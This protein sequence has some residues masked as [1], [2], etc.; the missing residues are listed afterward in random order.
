M[1]IW[2]NYSNNIINI[3]HLFIELNST[4]EVNAD[5]IKDGLVNET[6][7]SKTE[8]FSKT[9]SWRVNQAKIEEI[10]KN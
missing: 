8:E 9:F 10:K 7:G 4:K 6:Y 1:K 2:E 5:Y 3:N